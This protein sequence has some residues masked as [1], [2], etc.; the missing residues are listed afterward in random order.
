[1]QFRTMIGIRPREDNRREELLNKLHLYLD[2]VHVYQSLLKL[3]EYEAIVAYQVKIGGIK[4][5]RVDIYQFYSKGR[6]LLKLLV[7]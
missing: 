5:S 3:Y 4:V 7:F 2:K 6:K 1:M